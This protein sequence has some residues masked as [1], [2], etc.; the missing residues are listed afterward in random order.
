MT[1]IISS[2]KIVKIGPIDAYIV[3]ASVILWWTFL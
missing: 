1:I 3:T 2:Q